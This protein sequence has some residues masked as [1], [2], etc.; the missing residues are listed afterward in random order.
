M[1]PKWAD[2]RVYGKGCSKLKIPDNGGQFETRAAACHTQ[3]VLYHKLPFWS[4]L[5]KWRLTVWI[6][7]P[8]SDLA[9]PVQFRLHPGVLNRFHQLLKPPWAGSPK[10]AS[11]WRLGAS[12][13][14]SPALA[15]SA[16]GHLAMCSLPALEWRSLGLPQ[17][18]SVFLLHSREPLFGLPCLLSSY[19]RPVEVSSCLP[20]HPRASLVSGLPVTL[21]VAQRTTALKNTFSNNHL[22]FSLDKKKGQGQ[23]EL[24]ALAHLSYKVSSTQTG[25]QGR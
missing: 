4:V 19:L 21:G 25:G 3:S 23:R 6:H 14:L 11:A 17:P 2:N 20:Q 13:F 10:E 18:V 24:I 1:P 7:T 22:W 8:R 16:L 12:S 5:S 9:L 15:V